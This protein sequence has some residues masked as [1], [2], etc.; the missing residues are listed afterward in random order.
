MILD[1]AIGDEIRGKPDADFRLDLARLFKETLADVPRFERAGI[2]A[3]IQHLIPGL[4][5]LEG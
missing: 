3:L 4:S 5:D 2:D 1:Y